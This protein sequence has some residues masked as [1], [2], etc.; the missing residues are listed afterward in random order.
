MATNV[1]YTSL[2][3]DLTRYAERGGSALSDPTVFDQI[4][5][6]IN[7]AERKLAQE[8]KLLGQIEVFNSVA[9]SGGLQANNPVV[10]KPDRWRKTVSLGFGTGTGQNTYTPLYARGYEYALSYWADSTQTDV[11]R[12]YSDV[13]LEHWWISPCPDQ[14]YPLRAL[15]YMQPPLL[16][17]SNETNFWSSYTPNALLYGAMVQMELFL[18][19]PGAVS[20]WGP[21]YDRELGELNSQ[22]LQRILDRAAQRTA[23]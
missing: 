2:F 18:K 16:D 21:Q 3:Q 4:P 1:T 8:L 7:A 22:D 9:P 14:A 20:Q 13:D 11:P 19:E 12:F 5:R 23:P 6:L 15:C 10:A 17:S